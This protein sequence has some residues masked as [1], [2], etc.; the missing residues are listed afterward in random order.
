MSQ[1]ILLPLNL[2]LPL[3]EVTQHA[4]MNYPLPDRQTGQSIHRSYLHT[5]SARKPVP[6]GLGGVDFLSSEGFLRGSRF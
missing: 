2:G 4:I 3:L 6:R 1:R 5:N